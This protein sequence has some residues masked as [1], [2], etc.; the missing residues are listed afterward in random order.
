MLPHLHRAY[1]EPHRRYH[2]LEHV[3]DCLR[4]LAA[5]PGLST[6]DRRLLEWAIWWHDAVYDPAR[7][8]NEAA[9]ADLARR[10]LAA[11]GASEPE[12]EEVARLILLTKGHAVPARDRL[13]AVL[14]SIDLAI[15]GRSPEAYDRYAAQV[16]QE[17]AFVP[18]E[19]FRAGRAAVLRH[20]LDAPAIYPDP[21]FRDRLEAPARANLERELA[22]LQG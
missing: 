10:D 5:T 21:R 19:A 15:L 7:S 2:T 6:H 4:E 17:Y 18:D 12:R 14:V 8:D 20:F 11:L 13:G 9:S 1:Q 16:R 22:S 3:D